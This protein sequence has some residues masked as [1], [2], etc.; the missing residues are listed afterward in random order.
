MATQ[1]KDY[2]AILGVKKD[3]S[4][5][6]VKTAFRK[7]ARKYH[8]DLHPD[9]PQAS[10]KFTE[11]NEANEVLSDPEKRKKYDQY[12]P[13]WDQYQ[14]WDRAG[15]PGPNPFEGGGSPFGRPGA[16]G[17]QFQYQTMTPEEMESVFGNSSPFSDF[18]N[19]MFGGGGARGRASYPAP[20]A[21][22]QDVEGEVEITL[23]E[24]AG[25]T[26]RTVELQ[27]AKGPRRVEVKI[28]AGIREGARVRAAGQGAAGSGGG[29]AGDLYIRVKVRPHPVFTRHGDDL[30]IEVPVPM[31]AALVGGEVEVPTIA[32]KKVSLRIPAETQNGK[33]MRLRGLGMPRLSRDGKGDL[34]AQLE[35]RLP[36]PLSPEMREWA[37]Q[38]PAET[39]SAS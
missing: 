27:T 32:G 38:I 33:V 13:Q 2:Y 23:E 34:L 17:Q 24:A 30:R 28:P 1:F 19:S 26:A 11:V 21:L 36:L 37:A 18:F 4:A 20:A 5:K 6:E 8:P 12:G 9:D 25:G 22:G 31:R 10:S 39:P 29:R 35:V 3:A 14:S 7:L 15:R 16:G